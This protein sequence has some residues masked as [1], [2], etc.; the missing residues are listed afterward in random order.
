MAQIKKVQAGQSLKIPAAT[1]NAMVDA[2]VAHR[3]SQRDTG[4]QARPSFKQTGIVLIRN[5]SSVEIPRFGILG[6]DG[7]II[8]PTANL[9]EFQSNFALAG[10][11][12]KLPEHLGQFAISQTPLPPGEIGRAVVDGVC[13]VRVAVSDPCHQFADVQDNQA[14]VLVSQ[15]AGSA[16]ILWREDGLGTKWALVR[17]A[18]SSHDIRR[19]K[20]SSPLDRCG[21]AEAMRLS[22]GG[23]HSPWEQDCG[24]TDCPFLLHDTLGIANNAPAGAVG[25]AKWQAD[26]QRWELLQLGEDCCASS[27]SSEVSSSSDYSSSSSSESSSSEFSSSSETSSSSEEPSSS[28]E[29]SSSEY[30]SSSDSSSSSSCP[31]GHGLTTVVRTLSPCPERIGNRVWYPTQRLTFECGLLVAVDDGDPCELPY[32]CE[33][34]SSS[35]SDSSSSSSSDD[36]SSGSS[37]SGSSSGSLSS[38][39]S[40]LSSNS[41]SSNSSS[42]SSDSSSS[43]SSSNISSNGSSSSE[44]NSS[45]TSPESSTSSSSGSNYPTSSVAPSSS[46]FSSSSSSGSSSES[47]SVSE[48]SSSSVPT[49]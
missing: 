15:P 9:D 26:S 13:P 18:N 24:E 47:S 39:S 30:S 3:E 29:S 34:S 43:H 22:F 12:P 25:W 40:S 6:I 21:S 4:R 1:F 45:S 36:S 16:R 32:C 11:A 49:N 35:S 46:T 27:S 23:E 20:L 44:S 14:T 2:A 48:S 10:N 19:F 7:V 37:S 42:N 31:S 8:E 38:G 28:S 41:S 33:P 17:L 5:E